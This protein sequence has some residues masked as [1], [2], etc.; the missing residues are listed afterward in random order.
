MIN[1]TTVK[2]VLNHY[3]HVLLLHHYKNLVVPV[4]SVRCHVIHLLS[5]LSS[6]SQ[7]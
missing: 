4:L 6:I 7:I 5:P 1:P 2:H 3:H